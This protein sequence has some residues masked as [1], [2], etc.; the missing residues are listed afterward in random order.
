MP[1]GTLTIDRVCL[2]GS[3]NFCFFSS[4]GSLWSFSRKSIRVTEYVLLPILLNY[5]YTR[6]LTVLPTYPTALDARGVVAGV[7]SAQLVKKE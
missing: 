5:E 6:D 2:L 4:H 7:F 1:Y 3:L